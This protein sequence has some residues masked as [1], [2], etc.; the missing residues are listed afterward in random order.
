MA[1]KKRTRSVASDDS[2]ESTAAQVLPTHLDLK[3]LAE[4]ARGCTACD[5]YRGATQTVFGEGPRK[6][7]I[8]L[9]GEQPG[10]REDLAGHP[11]VGPAGLLLDESLRA[12]GIE[13]KEVYITNV[14]KHFKFTLR[15][16]RR[17]HQKPN[18]REI[19]AC[20]PWLEAELA[21]IKPKALV[22]LGATPAQALMGREFRITLHRGEIIATDYCAR[23]LATWHPAAIL[24][25]PD[26][27]R[28]QEM[29]DQL[30]DDLRQAI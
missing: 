11:F 15:G 23:T 5:L 3:A 24:R 14:V 22:C 10:D 25:M 16:K 18:S 21:V 30:V 9:I 6:A 1:A 4:A 17:L 29:R 26:K 7:K 8:I 2:E 19:H 27:D 20:R 12:A 28:R 13:R